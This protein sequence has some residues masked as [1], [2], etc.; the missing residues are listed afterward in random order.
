MGRALARKNK[1][2]CALHELRNKKQVESWGDCDLFTGVSRVAGGKYFVKFTIF[3]LK[4][5]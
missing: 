4:L 3:S 5:V 2:P 1:N